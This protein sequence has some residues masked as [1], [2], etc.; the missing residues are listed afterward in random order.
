MFFCTF[1]YT[2]CSGDGTDT[3]MK[4][5]Q[6]GYTSVIEVLLKTLLLRIFLQRRPISVSRRKE[7]EL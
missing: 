6:P 2:Y 4:S 7:Q 5:R 3:E 1:P